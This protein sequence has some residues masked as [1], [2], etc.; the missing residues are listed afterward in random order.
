LRLQ[1]GGAAGTLDVPG[2]QAS[3]FLQAFGAALSLPVPVLP[4]HTS[5]APLARL[6]AAI[7]GAAG[8]TGKIGTDIA[9]LMQ[10]EIGEAAEP[11][12]PGRGGSSAMAHKRNP[13]LSIAARAAAIR[14]PGYVATLLAA[15]DQEHERAAGAWQAEAA[16]WPALM[17]CASGGIAAMAQA[18]QGLEVNA[19]RMAETLSLLPHAQLSP[20][21]P[22]MIA[23]TLADHQA[24]ESDAA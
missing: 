24:F 19:P 4:W 3:A 6:A 8:V 7:A 11:A 20:A 14:M 18:L 17:L 23:K 15:Q 9:L 21:I 16:T 22:A 13:T 12:A 10:P 2:E 5:R 1:C